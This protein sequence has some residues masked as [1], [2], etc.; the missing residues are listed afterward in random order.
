L[1]DHLALTLRS[2][3]ADVERLGQE[4]DRFA[5]QHALSPQAYYAMNLALE[6]IV[7][8]VVSHGYQDGDDRLITVEV[9][10]TPGEVT[11]R[12]EDEAPAF[13]PLQVPDPDTTAPL[14][15]RHPGGLGIHLSKRML[16]GL[17]YSRVDGKNRI[18][19]YKRF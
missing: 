4:F 15:Q 9:A 12:V 14:E 11:A 8:N 7:M 13:D 5:E 17:Q 3:Q 1:T 2:T 10:I 19:M 16:D 6:E 18:D